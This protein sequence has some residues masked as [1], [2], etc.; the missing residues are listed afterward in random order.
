MLFGNSSNLMRH[1]CDKI[2]SHGMPVEGT[3]REA[4]LLCQLAETMQHDL[5]FVNSIV[6]QCKIFYFLYTRNSV[7]GSSKIFFLHAFFLD[8]LFELAF[9]SQ[10]DCLILNLRRCCEGGPSSLIFSIIQSQMFLI[11]FWSCF[12][13]AG[14]S[15]SVSYQ[16]KLA[17]PSVSERYSKQICPSI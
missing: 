4:C 14:I 16:Q 13:S 10:H 2:Q 11:N 6:H 7:R 3:F 5:T 12:A 15:N 17:R 9:W 1:H 8:R